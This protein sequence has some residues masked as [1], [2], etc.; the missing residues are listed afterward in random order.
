MNRIRILR[1]L[2]QAGCLATLSLACFTSGCDNPS[3]PPPGQQ[4]PA[5]PQPA[6][7]A[8]KAVA[9]PVTVPLQHG[10][11]RLTDRIHPYAT[12]E[13][14]IGRLDP[15]QRISN[16]SLFF[17]PTPEQRRD[18]A[19]LAAAQVDPKSPQFRQWLTAQS[20]AARFGARQENID[21]ASAWLRSQ[22]LE[23]HRTS[24]SVCA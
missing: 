2:T 12:P 5:A 10:F 20:Y 7:P 16:V 11:V 17:K 9:R 1:G 8:V 18:R 6:T 22:G 23:V 21:A 3:A 14:D 19:A 24:R 4:A 13:N 15:E